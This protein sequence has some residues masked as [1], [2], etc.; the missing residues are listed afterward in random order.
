VPVVRLCENVHHVVLLTTAEFQDFHNSEV[1]ASSVSFKIKM[2]YDRVM[3]ME[4][5]NKVVLELG[6][7]IT[8]TLN[9]CTVHGH[10]W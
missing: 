3:C 9:K 5:S 1:S 6:R 10:F 7:S 8:D 4:D 2:C